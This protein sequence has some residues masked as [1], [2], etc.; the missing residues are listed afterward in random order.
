MDPDKQVICSD[1]GEIK[2]NLDPESSYLIFEKPA[3]SRN[4]T[5]F[6]EI[7]ASFTHFKRGAETQGIYYDHIHKRLMLIVKVFPKQKERIVNMIIKQ[8]LPDNIDFYI[9]GSRL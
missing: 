5:Q 1:F 3:E 4:P 7:L 8:K 6:E 9:Y 2:E